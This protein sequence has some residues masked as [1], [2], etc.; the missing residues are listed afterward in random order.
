MGRRIHLTKRERY[1]MRAADVALYWLVEQEL[2]GERIAVEDL[3][4]SLRPY[5]NS[6]PGVGYARWEAQQDAGGL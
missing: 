2:E 5:Q 4:D 1:L 6:H 3:F